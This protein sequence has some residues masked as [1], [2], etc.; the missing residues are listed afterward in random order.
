MQLNNVYTKCTTAHKMINKKFDIIL[1][2]YI[3]LK[4][5][6]QVQTV[7]TIFLSKCRMVRGMLLRGETRFGMHGNSVVLQNAIYIKKI[8]KINFN[9]R[10]DRTEI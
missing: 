3:I 7:Y 10:C 4:S 9:S 6:P 5:T 8:H 2:P 1:K